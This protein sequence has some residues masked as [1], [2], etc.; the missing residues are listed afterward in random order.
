MPISVCG[1]ARGSPCPGAGASERVALGMPTRS[2]SR[3]GGS[4]RSSTTSS[5]SRASTRF[6]TASPTRSAE[7][8]PYDALHIYEADTTR[9]E[10]IP[11]LA[12]TDWENEIMRTRPAFGQ[13]ITGWAVDKREPVL[14]NDAHL[15]SRVAFIPGTPA[16]PE[17]L[18]S[19]PLI[20]RGV[21]QGR[22]QRLPRRR[23]RVVR[24][25]RVRAR[26]VVRRRGSAR[27]RQR[28]GACAPRAPGADGLADRPLQP[29]QLPRAAARR[30]HAREPRTRLRRPAHVR[31]RRVQARQ[32]HLRP[33]RRGRDPRRAR[34]DDAHRSYAPAT[35]SAASAARSSPSSFPPATRET[36]S[37]SHA[38]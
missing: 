26:E 2:S 4:R 29:P 5:R 10:L 32:R 25:G 28:A 27:A 7:L 35:S 24:G 21:A 8:I 23:G 12:R 17:A 33:W 15:D 18:I 30:A 31:H 6:S 34:R 20:A 38:A 37:V 22:P 13:G 3:T 9:R 16:E 36:R 11:V 19:I 1:G 14:A